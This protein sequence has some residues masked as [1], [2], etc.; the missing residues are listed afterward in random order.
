MLMG[1]NMLG[2]PIHLSND[3]MLSISDVQVLITV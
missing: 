3:V 1:S 2:K